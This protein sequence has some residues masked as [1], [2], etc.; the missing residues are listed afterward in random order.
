MLN[1]GSTYS[2]QIVT[3]HANYSILEHDGLT[4]YCPFKNGKLGETCKLKVID[5]SGGKPKFEYFVNNIDDDELIKCSDFYFKYD[6]P[7][8]LFVNLLINGFYEKIK[9]SKWLEFSNDFT[10]SEYIFYK[11]LLGK[12]KIVIDL[13]N[14]NSHYKFTD[15][16][17]YNFEIIRSLSSL[18]SGVNRLIIKDVGDN[19]T[20]NIRNHFSNIDLKVGDIISLEYRG[21]TNKKEPIL[22]KDLGDNFITPKK[23]ISDEDIDFLLSSHLI[24]YDLEIQLKSQINE[25]DGFWVLTACNYLS[26]LSSEFISKN[27]LENSKQSSKIFKSISGF[28]DS[29]QFF[30][31]IPPNTR[32]RLEPQYNNSKEQI[33]LNIKVCEFLLTNGPE[34]LFKKDF[35]YS[36]EDRVS[37]IRS[38]FYL[39]YFNSSKLGE[40]NSIVQDI[41]QVDEDFNELVA[42]FYENFSS[43]IISPFLRKNGD[44]FFDDMQT[45]RS[46]LIESE[47]SKMVSIVRKINFQKLGLSWQTKL[48]FSFLCFLDFSNSEQNSFE[49]LLDE[50]YDEL[51]FFDFEFDEIEIEYVEITEESITINKPILIFSSVLGLFFSNKKMFFVRGNG[52]LHMLNYF[53]NKGHSVALEIKD[54]FFNRIY[55]LDY[56]CMF[57]FGMDNLEIGSEVSLVYKQKIDKK[58]PYVFCTYYSQSGQKTKEL[59]LQPSQHKFFKHDRFMPGQEVIGEIKSVNNEGQYFAVEKNPS[60]KIDNE[61]FNCYYDGQIIKKYLSNTLSSCKICNSLLEF[62]EAHSKCSSCDYYEYEFLEIYIPKINKHIYVN[63]FSI[64]SGDGFAFFQNSKVGDIFKFYLFDEMTKYKLENHSVNFFKIRKE[65]VDI[66][67]HKVINTS[68]KFKR[69]G[70]YLMWLFYEINL[71]Y[72]NKL[73]QLEGF[74]KLVLS[75]SSNYR[76]PKGYLISGLDSYNK[77]LTSY[78][79][80]YEFSSTHLDEIKSFENDYEKTVE[81]YPKFQKIF[82][83][84]NML[85]VNSN[86][87]KKLID[88]F[89]GSNPKLAKLL[90]IRNLLQSEDEKSD[91]INPIND[92]IKKNLIEND[93]SFKLN[94]NSTVY[95]QDPNISLLKMIENKEIFEDQAHEF[96][97]TFHYPTLNK[98]Q[99]NIIDKLKTQ[100]ANDPSKDKKLSDQIEKIKNSVPDWSNEIA[101]DLIYSVLKNITAFLNTNDG[102]LIIGVSDDQVLKGLDLDYI[103]LH[104]FDGFQRKFEEYWNKLVVAP[105]NF[106][107]YVILKRILYKEME[108]CIVE[109]S[110]PVGVREACF[111]RDSPG[112][113]PK[114]LMKNSS[115]TKEVEIVDIQNWTR[116]RKNIKN[117]PTSVYLMKTGGGLTKIGITNNV[118]TRIDSL[119]N[120]FPKIELIDNWVFP[121]RNIAL[122]YEKR[123]QK[124]FSSKNVKIKTYTEFF[125]LDNEDIIYLKNELTK[126]RDSMEVNNDDNSTLKFD[127]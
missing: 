64:V 12:T 34:D 116:K 107:Q 121:F 6:D 108:F 65:N 77:I 127:I 70:Y 37:I 94:I 24:N 36:L 55:H 62:G 112:G 59:K 102:K 14:I 79:K 7:N 104:D 40:I 109:V 81:V 22:V 32:K 97:E 100:I 47:L 49:N 96:K 30:I 21:L 119:K 29:R 53:L 88:Y 114:L 9:L 68:Y 83:S 19:V 28:L 16:S 13:S 23:L 48:R 5:Y 57:D 90:L 74:N 78:F 15:N 67:N 126:L 76:S 89:E 105:Q 87:Y 111:I 84:L 44:L 52:K 103:K 106:R 69:F 51:N 26:V 42:C 43:K 41:D 73:H 63:R 72:R 11:K 61:E 38:L 113:L 110:F 1:K 124:E 4:Y 122:I 123:F 98:K 85:S 92:L 125:K 17:H 33:D 3:T 99:T 80:N 50:F 95:E 58:N 54:N 60:Y 27:E 82:T 25:K 10:K 120:D 18:N 93:K 35:D 66:Y 115:T 118:S 56:N 117:D 2:F 91:L 101:N 71:H 8:Y 45:K 75:L 86:E 46:F 31:D 20:Y 39:N